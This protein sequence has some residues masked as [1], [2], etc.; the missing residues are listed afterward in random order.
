MVMGTIEY[1]SPEQAMGQ[2]ADTRSD[3]YTL[4]MILYELFAGQRP[5]TGDNP[6]SRLS[7]RL[8]VAAPDPRTIR[9]DV[10]AYLAK[11][12]LR[13]L[14][15]DPDQRYQRVEDII[16]D[17]DAHQAAARPWGLA[18]ERWGGW[19]VAAGAGA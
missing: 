7:A 6:M 18:W 12:I 1:L 16:P 15:R 11:I 2:T 17:L 13:C 4:G 8:H 9:S 5:F 19:K 10:P 3:I 14:E